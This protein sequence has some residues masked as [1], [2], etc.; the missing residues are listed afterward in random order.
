MGIRKHED[1]AECYENYLTLK[2]GEPGNAVMKK[3]PTSAAFLEIAYHDFESGTENIVLRSQS[4][5]TRDYRYNADI[6]L[7]LY[8]ENGKLSDSEIVAVGEDKYYDYDELGL[9]SKTVI[10]VQ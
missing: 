5:K 3:F 8:F 4:S 9:N 2:E 6:K 10:T 1:T 7:S